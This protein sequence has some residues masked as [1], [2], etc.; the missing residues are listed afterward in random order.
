MIYRNY[1]FSTRISSEAHED[2]SGDRVSRPGRFISGDIPRKTVEYVNAIS[3]SREEMNDAYARARAQ[4]K[5]IN[6]G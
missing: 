6:A 1:A 5:R 3:F 4:G 2:K